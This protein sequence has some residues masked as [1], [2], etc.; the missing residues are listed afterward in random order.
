[1]RWNEDIDGTGDMPKAKTPDWW[2][3]I[4]FVIHNMF[5]ANYCNNYLIMN[6]KQALQFAVNIH[7]VSDCMI[8]YFNFM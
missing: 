6:R 5:H 1:M 4:L 7:T 2:W 8:L 3:W